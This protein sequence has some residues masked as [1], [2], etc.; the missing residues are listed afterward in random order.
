MAR[1][2]RTKSAGKKPRY[3][4]KRK[5]TKRKYSKKRAVKRTTKRRRYTKKRPMMRRRKSYKKS[6]GPS[7]G[8]M[9]W[10]VNNFGMG[11]MASAPASMPR[12][13]QRQMPSSS[14][15]GA[16]FPLLSESEE[17]KIGTEI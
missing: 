16:I 2:K 11:G 8:E 7:I 13:Y 5:Y 1:A 14:F 17:Y 15:G 12:K 6:S 4:G 3:S 10:V 9:S